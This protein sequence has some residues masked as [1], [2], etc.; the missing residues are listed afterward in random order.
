[1]PSVTLHHATASPPGVI[2]GHFGLY[3]VACLDVKPTLSSICASSMASTTS[4]ASASPRTRLGAPTPHAS[5]DSTF[6]RVFI[7]PMPENVVAHTEAEVKKQKTEGLLSLSFDSD[8]APDKSDDVSKIIK[9]HALSFFL[10]HGGKKK[11][12]GEEQEQSVA[13]EMLKRWKSS[14]WSHIWRHRHKAKTE[15]GQTNH[16]VGGSFEIGRLLGVD[17]FRGVSIDEISK[18][19]RASTSGAQSTAAASKTG[20]EGEQQTFATAPSRFSVNGDSAA[21]SGSGNG[22]HDGPSAT[23][24]TSSTR[25]I[26]SLS[27]Q[28]DAIGAPGPSVQRTPTS[29]LRGKSDIDPKGKGKQKMVRYASNTPPTQPVPPRQVLERTGS[30]LEAT[31][32]AAASLS[33]SLAVSDDVQWGDV[34]FRGIFVHIVRTYVSNSSR[35]RMLVR[36]LYTKCETLSHQFN[37]SINRTTR[38]LHYEDWAEFLVAW[39]RDSLEIYE[40]HVS[41]VAFPPVGPFTRS[42]SRASLAKKCSL[43][44]STCPTSFH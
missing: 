19:G 16:W 18:A 22:F 39:R 38:N 30:A 41:A 14:E 13:D 9:A 5:G 3:G 43:N 23:P 15:L 37:E 21:A 17:I 20:T 34:V 32:S 6:G 27:K 10:H 4:I 7:G 11:D 31:S 8:E 26:S 42:V 36:I 29:L 40:D 44:T 25:L 33:P 35:D 24:A 28:T 2:A 12:W 1:M